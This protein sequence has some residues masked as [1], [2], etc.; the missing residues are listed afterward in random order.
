M[1]DH[2][3]KTSSE[4]IYIPKTR[5]RMYTKAFTNWHLHIQLHDSKLALLPSMLLASAT[6]GNLN[7]QAPNPLNPQP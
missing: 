5:Q 6:Y 7:P 2:L 3:P 1:L 4:D